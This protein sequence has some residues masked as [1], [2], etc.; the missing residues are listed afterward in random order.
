LLSE[1]ASSAHSPD[2]TPV[3]TFAQTQVA[4]FVMIK[5][6][7]GALN[8]QGYFE[9]NKNDEY[10]LHHQRSVVV[11]VVAGYFGVHLGT[12]RP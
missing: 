4:I 6:Q 12:I 1:I 8:T 3:S 11:V 2:R 10:L 9:R 5:Q 7:S